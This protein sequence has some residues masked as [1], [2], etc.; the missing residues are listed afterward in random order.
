[1]DPTIQLYKRRK[2]GMKAWIA[3]NEQHAGTNKWLTELT[4]EENL[5][6]QRIYTGKAQSRYSLKM[7]CDSHRH[8]NLRMKSASEH[9]SY[10][11]PNQLTRVCHLLDTIKCTN[12]LLMARIANIQC[13]QDPK[14]KLHN[15]EKAVAFLLPACPVALRQAARG[16]EIVDDKTTGSSSMT[17]KEGVGRTGVD[18]RW[19]PRKDF[20]V[21][22]EEQKDELREFTSSTA[23]KKQKDA[24]AR[25]KARGGGHPTSPTN[26]QKT[27]NDA[28]NT[29]MS[30]RSV[31]K[32]TAA[33]VKMGSRRKRRLPCLIKG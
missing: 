22:T 16:R 12:L 6:K 7:H 4:K 17:L 32:I 19:Y 29:P 11:L 30:E 15:F 28:K 13:D 9:V 1:M 33:V 24:S 5:L 8:S 14:G 26:K 23:G 3:L 25:L 27:N 2:D 21:L 20:A 10:Q 18:F 31:N